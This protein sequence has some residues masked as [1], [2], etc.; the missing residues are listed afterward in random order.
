MTAIYRGY[1][2]ARKESESYFNKG[3]GISK[4]DKG[5][6]MDVFPFI[7]IFIFFQQW[8]VASKIQV[9]YFCFPRKQIPKEKCYFQ[10]FYLF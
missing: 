3:A 9:L 5:R 7:W 4:Y 10:V 6:V 8:F 1:S 2:E